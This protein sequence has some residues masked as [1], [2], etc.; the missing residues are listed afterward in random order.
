MDRS[1]LRRFALANGIKPILRPVPG[2]GHKS[3]L[4]V[5]PEQAD[6]IRKQRALGYV[7]EPPTPDKRDKGL[8]K[9]IERSQLD[10]PRPQVGSFAL[11]SG[12]LERIVEW[13]SS[14]PDGPEDEP[15]EDLIQRV[16]EWHDSR[17]DD[18]THEGRFTLADP[19]S[20]GRFMAMF[21]GP[22]PYVAWEQGRK[23]DAIIARLVP[24]NETKEAEFWMP[25]HGQTGRVP[26]PISIK[27]RVWAVTR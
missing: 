9:L 19:E 22:A 3:L 23:G 21:F 5:T 8:A 24:T 4:T 17:K 2:S 14:L 13:E 27:A 7:E 16:Y 6:K 1:Y 10:S 25:R 26:V 15:L 12:R 18:L 20:G 11:I